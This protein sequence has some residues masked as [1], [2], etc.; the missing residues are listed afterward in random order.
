[1]KQHIEIPLS[2]SK[3]FKLVVFS[4]LFVICGLWMSIYQPE[5]GNGIL[6][7]VIVKNTIGFLATLMGGLGIY[8]IGKKLFD[9]KP[10]ITID[11]EGIVDNSGALSMGRIFWKDVIDIKEKKVPAGF[12]NQKF[13]SITVSNPEEY[14]GKTHSRFKQKT[15]R[16]NLKHSGTPINISTNGLNFDFEE[17]KAIVQTKW[18]QHQ[19]II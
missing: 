17:L 19:D 5:S 4:I 13:I 12:S 10:G 15:M 16:M 18:K 9:K 7:N 6:D 2:K 1:M 11:N 8:F 14:I 3:L